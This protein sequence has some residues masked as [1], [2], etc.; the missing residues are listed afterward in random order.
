LRPLYWLR[1]SGVPSMLR[2]NAAPL[3]VPATVWDLP[4]AR[5]MYV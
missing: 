4:L 3:S 2:N 1:V 5:K